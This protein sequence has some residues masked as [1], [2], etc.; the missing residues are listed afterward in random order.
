MDVFHC[1]STALE[2]LGQGEVDLYIP[3]NQESF[4]HFLEKLIEYFGNPGSVYQ[5]KRA[6]F[7]KYLEDIKIEI[8]LINEETDD[9]KNIIKFEKYLKENEEALEN[10][11]M[12]KQQSSGLSIQE[13]YRK[14]LEFLNKIIKL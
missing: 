4:N 10:Y 9:W 11:K 1:G 7:V 5:F 3:V 8:F 2:I 14:K 13:Y 6:R 12:L